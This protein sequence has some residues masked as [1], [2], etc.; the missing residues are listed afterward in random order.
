M[1]G[2]LLFLGGWEKNYEDNSLSHEM[3]CLQVRDLQKQVEL[4]AVERQKGR[5]GRTRE[6]E[7]KTDRTRSKSYSPGRNPRAPHTRHLSP[8]VARMDEDK[9][10]K[11]KVE[12]SVLRHLRLMRPLTREPMSNTISGRTLWDPRQPP[13]TVSSLPRRLSTQKTAP[14]RPGLH[15]H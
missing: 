13:K 2:F 4:L 14:P 10:A 5:Q 3:F 15:P 12:C 6:K 1:L 9:E 8:R 11:D 7:A